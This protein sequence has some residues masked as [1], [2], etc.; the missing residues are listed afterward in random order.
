MVAFSPNQIVELI[1]YFR[2]AIYIY[3]MFILK[4]C[5]FLFSIHFDRSSNLMIEREHGKLAPH[6]HPT[7][8][9]HIPLVAIRH[10]IFFFFLIFYSTYY[11]FRVQRDRK[12]VTK[13]KN[14][15]ANNVCYTYPYRNIKCKTQFPSFL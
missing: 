4:F 2:A 9:L 6:K 3:S 8:H 10:N 14:R 15:L 11:Y 1:L 5:F 13:K 12:I 7:H